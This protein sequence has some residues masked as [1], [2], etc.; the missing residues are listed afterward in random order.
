MN[1]ESIFACPECKNNLEY[2]GDNYLCSRCNKI[3]YKKN[4]KIF[5]YKK[6]D[7]VKST[8]DIWLNNL[9][10]KIKFFPK[11]YYLFINLFAPA[12][13]L[14]KKLKNFLKEA[15]PEDIILNLG[16]GSFRLNKGIINVDI[17][18]YKE[19]D[20]VSDIAKIPFKEESVDI[21]ILNAVLEHTKQP[22][23]VI[24]E[25]HRVLKRGGLIYITV[26]FIYP[27]HPS[28]NDYQRWTH[29]GFLEKMKG[30]EL[31]KS[32]IISGP[33]IA[34]ISILQEY[35]AFL[36]SFGFVPLYYFFWFLFMIV[37]TPLKLLDIFLIHHPKAKKIAAVFYY[38]YKK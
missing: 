8:E 19:V 25:S 37:T 22:E 2:H 1:I 10:N 28:P 16:S 4:S 13:L 35:L 27:L 20:I 23:L 17:E 3:Y 33:T 5:F 29:A 6:E 31:I 36:F 15:S 30:F 24:Q 38:I 18:P 32:G 14:D 26:P 11:L 12:P 7:D 9:K 34:L 21:I